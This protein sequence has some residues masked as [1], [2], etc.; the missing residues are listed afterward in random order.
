[1]A[2]KTIGGCIRTPRPDAFCRDVRHQQQPHLYVLTNCE[3]V[4]PFIE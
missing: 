1:M 3:D 4:I 2:D